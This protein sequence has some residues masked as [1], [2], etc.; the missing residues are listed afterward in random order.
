MSGAN[1]IT[2]NTYPT[3]ENGETVAFGHAEGNTNCPLHA[4][5]FVVSEVGA[6]SF[7]IKETD[8]TGVS[9]PAV[10]D[11]A[12]NTTLAM[13]KISHQL[14]YTYFGKTKITIQ[15]YRRCHQ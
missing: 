1:V 15:Q 6:G 4:K 8:L 5:P 13:L 9:V 12:A 7:K 14:S 11:M 2:I 10:K 3:L